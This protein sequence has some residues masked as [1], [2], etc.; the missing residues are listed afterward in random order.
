MTFKVPSS[1]DLGVPLSSIEAMI[2]DTETTGLNTKND[3]VLELAGVQVSGG[4]LKLKNTKS[5]LINP[6]IQ[7]PPNNTRIHGISDETVKSA[8]GFEVGIR[9]FVEWIGNRYI[10]GYSLGFDLAILEEEHKRHGMVWSEPRVL[11]AEE[12]VQLLAPNLP[13]LALDT[14]LAWLNISQPEDR[15]RALPD[16]IVTAEIFLKLIPMLKARGVSTYAEAD[17]LCKDIRRRTGGL[18]R[19]AVP[20]QAETS[21][22]DIYPYKVKICDIMMA[23]VIVD[24]N[25]TLQSAL[26]ILIQKKIGSV[27]IRLDGEKQFGILTESDIL[28]AINRDG[29]NILSAPVVKYSSKLRGIIHKKE[30]IYRAMVSM[31]ATNFRRLAVSDDNGDIVGIVSSRDIYGKFSSDAIGLGKDI[32]QA[33]TTHDLGKVWAGLTS[34]SH[35]LINSGI[36]SRTITAIISRELRGLTQKTCQIAEELTR[37]EMNVQSIPNYTML[38]LGSG[39]RGESMLAMDQDNAIIFDQADPKG[40]NDKV[41]SLIGKY[42]AEILNEVGVSFCDGGVMAS[43]TA[44]RRDLS[45][46]ERL[47]A[48]WLAETK[49]DDL[50]NSDIFFD[51]FPVHGDLDMA[52]KLRSRAIKSARKAKP[53][54]SLLG[55]RATDFKVPIGYFGRWK[56]ENGR[57]D[58]KKGGIMP[59]FSTARVLS[60]QHGL[61]G[62]S[63]TDRLQKYR[64]LGH[65][66]EKLIDDL[67]E[68][69]GLLLELILRQQLDDLEAGISPS[70]NV[71]VTKLNGLD[72]HKLKWAL[73]KLDTL[74]NLLGIPAI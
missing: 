4:C 49:P 25:S 18:N 35:S 16:A 45:S 43:N 42:T 24:R 17:R 27:I 9:D 66:P 30:F 22:V 40:E 39:G 52:N 19:Q 53:F 1:H 34:V 36:D 2:I 6:G 59:I 47:I 63:T 46:W 15:H 7:I 28:K 14:V 62:R 50:L 72:Q 54:L 70:N 48:K 71:A 29:S 64:A 12:L 3:R 57:V 51:S 74:P 58:L 61:Y 31:G 55:K 20:V 26:E 37:A 10:I 32:E 44:W 23:P 41:L 13:N 73:D 11:D 33:Q 65:V 68:A 8:P 5:V 38:V 69:H 60:L 56:L 21:N 67:L